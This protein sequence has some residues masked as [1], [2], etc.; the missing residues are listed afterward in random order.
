MGLY[1]PYRIRKTQ[2]LWVC[3]ILI[4]LGQP[5]VCVNLFGIGKSIKLL[6]KRG[7]KRKKK[8]LTLEN[9]IRFSF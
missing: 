8:N 6:F 2:G 7:G 1:N 9:F 3:I 5:K 4:G